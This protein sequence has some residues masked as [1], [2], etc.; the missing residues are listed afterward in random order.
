MSKIRISFLAIIVLGRLIMLQA[1]TLVPA[2]NATNVSVDMPFK[3][4][5]STA[6]VL[7]GAG[8]V[9]LYESNG[10]L[11]STIALS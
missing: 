4:T 2:N 7:Q 1:Q 5:F 10:T 9:R 3:L 6:P 11:V 8:N